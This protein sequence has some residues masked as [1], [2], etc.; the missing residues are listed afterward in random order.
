MTAN[1]RVAPRERGDSEEVAPTHRRPTAGWIMVLALALG[2]LASVLWRLWLGH[3]I[4]SPV[5]HADEDSY[6]NAARAIAGGPSGWSSETALFRRVGYSLFISPVFTHGTGFL[7]SYRLVHLLNAIANAATLPLAYL[8][9]R[10]MFRLGQW[11]AFAAALVAVTLPATVFWSLVAMTDALM[12]VLLFGWLLALHWWLTS[13]RRAWPAVVTGTM[14][15]LLYMVHIRGTIIAIIYIAML[16][17]LLVRRHTGIKG[18]AAALAPL[19][20]LIALNQAIIMHLGDKVYLIKNIVAG[21]SPLKVFTESHRLLVFAAHN[22]TDIWYLCL[23]SGGLAGIAW[24]VTTIE[25]FKPSKDLAYRWTT[26][27]A[28]LSTIGVTLS[29]ALIMAGLI[30]NEAVYARYVEMFVPFWVLFGFAALLDAKLRQALGYAL[31]PVVVFAVGTPLIALRNSQALKHGQPLSYGAFGGPDVFAMTAGWHGFRP[32]V[33]GIV[34]VTC[35]VLLVALTR[36][37]R[38]AIPALLA[39]VLAGVAM[40]SGIRS[41]I[42]EPLGKAGKTVPTLSALGVGP[43]DHV[44]ITWTIPN[45]IG[46][47]MYHQVSWMELKTTD[48][49]K[50]GTNVVIAR[51]LPGQPRDWDGTK[52]GFHRVGGSVGQHW[53]VW[54]R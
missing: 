45:E 8:L 43:G 48:D 3:P 10:R 15:G 32:V 49:P 41:H 19:I 9:G 12:T 25:F 47:S 26:V 36:S 20:V 53:A 34:G 28:L 42:I 4:V 29:S 2:W 33:G 11:Q 31:V 1:V 7:E 27:V 13:A 6:V 40:M 14:A 17:L 54:R 39:I 46:F 30:G 5:A 23:A 16:L 51:W 50:P 52:R 35:L 21:G 18:A 24:A 38:L 22:G 37:R 44:A